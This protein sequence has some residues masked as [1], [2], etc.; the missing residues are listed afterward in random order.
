[1]KL[2]LRMD[3]GLS[4]RSVGLCQPADANPYA[5]TGGSSTGPPLRALLCRWLI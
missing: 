5:W 1:L 2:A 4:V 3:A